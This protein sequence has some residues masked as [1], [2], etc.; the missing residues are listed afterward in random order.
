MKYYTISLILS[1]I[2]NRFM[3]RVWENGI[4][5]RLRKQAFKP[6][7]KRCQ[8]WG[9]QKQVGNTPLKLKEFFGIFVLYIGGCITAVVLFLAELFIARLK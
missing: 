3:L 9:Q 8:P 5:E 2:Q 7:P 6:V 1:H 4:L